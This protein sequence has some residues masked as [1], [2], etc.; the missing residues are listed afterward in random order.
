MEVILSFI[1]SALSKFGIQITLWSIL[2]AVAWG[3]SLSQSLCG[4]VDFSDRVDVTDVV[5]L[6]NY[7]FA[8][9]PAPLDPA[10]GDLNCS[11][12]VDISDAV[13]M[14]NFIFAFG[15]APCCSSGTL[16]IVLSGAEADP[17]LSGTIDYGPF[18]VADSD[19]VDDFIRT[20]LEVVIDPAATVGD[21]ND[22]LIAIDARLSCMRSGSIFAELVVPPF[23]DPADADSA[24]ASLRESGAFLA[25]Y[26]T[27][28]P[29]QPSDAAVEPPFPAAAR[30][31]QLENEGFPS[32]W[33]ARQLAVDR[34]SPVTVI[35]GDVFHSLSP[36]NEIQSQ[37]FLPGSGIP[38]PT[39]DSS[40]VNNGNH[41]FQVAG[42]IGADFDSIGA[43]GVFPGPSSLLLLQCFCV[44][45]FASWTALLAELSSQ[46]PVSGRFILNTS[47]G[48]HDN[49]G[50]MTAVSKTQRILHALYWRAQVSGS[51]DRFLHFVAAGNEGIASNDSANATFTSPFAIAARYNSPFDML[52]GSTVSAADSA[53][54]QEVFSY[55]VQISAANATQLN[56]VLVVGASA[57]SGSEATWS[58]RP[59]DVRMFGEIIS[60]PCAVADA[61]CHVQPDGV[62]EAF[63]DGSSFAAPQVSGL[64]A[65][66]WSLSPG[67]SNSSTLGI[68]ANCFNGSW[69]D[70]YKAVLSLDMSVSGGDVRRAI[71]DIANSSDGATPDGVFDE[72][73]LEMY[74][75]SIRY[76]ENEAQNVSPPYP[77]DY[78]RFDL[79]GDGYT[80]E[81]PATATAIPFDLDVNVPP[82]YSVVYKMLC[83]LAAGRDTTFDENSVSDRDILMYYSFSGL[84]AGDDAVRDSIFGIGCAPLAVVGQS[85]WALAGAS[86]G[87]PLNL[88]ASN[89]SAGGSVTATVN[90]SRD[91][92]S[93]ACKQGYS[94]VSENSASAS[95]NGSTTGPGLMASGSVNLSVSATATTV[96]TPSTGCAVRVTGS[97]Y[98]KSNLDFIVDGVG[99]AYTFQLDV[100]GGVTPSNP[101]PG[102]YAGCSIEVVTIDEFGNEIDGFG[103]FNSYVNTLPFHLDGGVLTALPAGQH[104]RLKMLANAV[105]EATTGTAEGNKSGQINISY[106]LSVNQ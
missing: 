38:D 30:L 32:A 36:H 23:A 88:Q 2:I 11:G 49:D 70:A 96:G 15:P 8:G 20:R 19:F 41:G 94:W 35:V 14:V 42:V 55:V 33:N 82:A 43:T 73:D 4:D 29:I 34:S 77:R 86:I 16:G 62:I 91:S 102:L 52:T 90:E 13:T 59:S 28:R 89:Q 74:I 75:D 22:A 69:I 50:S 80:G 18:V 51:K 46:L 93:A 56:N 99:G 25:A 72:H 31:A 37:T 27:F 92:L 26:P 60:V 104:Y 9:G 7:L 64:A 39:F 106:S 81:R 71:L 5:Y 68:L 98:A 53:Q 45:G 12:R 47:F 87:P 10:G 61:H 21:V 103:G 76:F 6:I 97:T 3:E 78:S 48:Y 101:L 1:D 105:A 17:S 54:L 24:C 67:L 44:N 83:G 84:F 57:V 85:D 79:N 66:L 65:Y 63:V 100:S 95:S 58:N 40:G